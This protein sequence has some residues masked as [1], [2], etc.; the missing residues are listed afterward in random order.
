M[1]GRRSTAAVRDGL[2][3][4]LVVIALGLVATRPSAQPRPAV[5]VSA[6]PSGPCNG[7]AADPRQACLAA[8][9]AF[10]AR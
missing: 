10:L 7:L 1:G 3:V 2:V 4:A 5:V 6:V 8:A 9:H